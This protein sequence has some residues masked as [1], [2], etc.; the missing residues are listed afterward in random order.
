M[1]ASRSGS[2]VMLA[3]GQIFETT[4]GAWRRILAWHAVGPVLTMPIF[5]VR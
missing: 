1:I 5:G 4:G 3:S 2:L